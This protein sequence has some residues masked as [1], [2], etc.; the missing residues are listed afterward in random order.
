MPATT[1]SEHLTD[2]QLMARYQD[3]DEEA[4]CQIYKRHKAL[5]RHIIFNTLVHSAPSLL[6]RVHDLFQETFAAPMPPG[7][8]SSAVNGLYRGSPPLPG[9]LPNDVFHGN[10]PRRDY[11]RTDVLAEG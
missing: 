9:T 10:R 2:E 5:V 7:T 6:N 1:P 8:P 11:R 3:G 4:F